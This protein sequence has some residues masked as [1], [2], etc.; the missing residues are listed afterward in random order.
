MII[1]SVASCVPQQIITNEAVIDRVLSTSRHVYAGDLGALKSLVDTHLRY[2]GASERRM[3]SAG[4]DSLGYAV[5][6]GQEALKRAAMAPEEIDLVIYVGV[7]RGFLEPAMAYVVSDALGLRRAHC[8]DVLDA[9]MSWTRAMFLSKSLLDSGNY[10]KIMIVSCEM[11]LTT[12]P[13]ENFRF[14]TAE[15]IKFRLPGLTVGDAA[16]ATIL[17]KGD[18]PTPASWMFRFISV[19]EGQNLCFIPL[20]WSAEFAHRPLRSETVPLSFYSYYSEMSQLGHQSI[21]K[22]ADEYF[23]LNQDLFNRIDRVFCHAD[24]AL[25]YELWASEWGLEDKLDLIFTRYGNCAAS[26]IPLAID[27]SQESKRLLRG[28]DILLIVVSAGIS[29]ACVHFQF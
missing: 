12:S 27:L 14:R 18:N 15:D 5:R 26:S 22:V 28:D 7:S 25:S 4:E 1:Q 16:C 24:Q 9:C 23:R 8:F 13:D 17:S 11:N 20:P 29:A 2:I 3:R 10:E 6:A 21:R 19:P